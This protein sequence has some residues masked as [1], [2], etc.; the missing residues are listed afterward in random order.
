M[1]QVTILA[2]ELRRLTQNEL[3]DE[4]L[5]GSVEF[6]SEWRE[7]CEKKVVKIEKRWNKKLE[8][9]REDDEI[10]EKL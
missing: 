10:E 5:I 8:D 6:Q 1:A 9:P 7:F 2:F 4:G 3:V